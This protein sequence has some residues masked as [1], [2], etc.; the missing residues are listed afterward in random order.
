ML[1]RMLREALAG[2]KRQKGG[3]AVLTGLSMIV[4]LGAAALAIDVG[5][6]ALSKTQ[7]QSAVDQAALAGAQALA[8]GSLNIDQAKADAMA[9]AHR[10]PGQASDTVAAPVVNVTGSVATIQVTTTRTVPSYFARIFNNNS[11]TITASATARVSAAG[12]IPPGAPPFAIVAPNNIVWQGPSNLWS[13]TYTMEINPAGTDHF[14]YVDV[15]FQNKKDTKLYYNLLANGYS[16]PLTLDSQLYWIAPAEGGVTA[17]NNFASR[18]TQRGNHD[19]TKAK[20]GDPNLM[21]LPL[22]ESLPTSATNGPDWSL[23]TN[24]LKI[25]GFVGFWL[26]SV[27]KGREVNGRFPNFF[28]TGRFIKIFLPDDTPTVTGGQFFG[29]ATIQL[30]N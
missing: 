1:S 15:F 28:A 26:D 3:V 24:G 25:V 22:L 20:V 29:P 16:K 21:M 27:H 12:G 2:P 19:I 5:N 17:V 6:L 30:I 18:L 9:Y 23:T 14:T 4:L 10:S 7:L 11:N 8:P 13:Q